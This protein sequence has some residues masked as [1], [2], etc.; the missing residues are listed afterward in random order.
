VIKAKS[1]YPESTDGPSG[2]V[3]VA[4]FPEG[5]P[6]P[7]R[8]SFFSGDPNDPTTWSV[9]PVDNDNYFFNVSH[10]IGD[11]VACTMIKGASAVGF[12]ARTLPPQ[13][14]A[15]LAEPNLSGPGDPSWK[16]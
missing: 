8:R 10:T 12:G 16:P 7:I 13:C 15:W 3:Q 1:S 2:S 9:S 4:P 11:H 5:Y 14:A 6:E